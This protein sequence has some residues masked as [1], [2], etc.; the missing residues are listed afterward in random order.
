ML[1]ALMGHHMAPVTGTIA[2]A[3]ENGFILRLGSSQ[4]FFTPG[5]PINR[6]IRMLQQIGSAGATARPKAPMLL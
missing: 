2:H 1:K 3:Q 6:I 4:G 5:I